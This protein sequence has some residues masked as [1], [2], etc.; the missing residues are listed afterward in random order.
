MLSLSIFEFGI[1]IDIQNFL[2][3]RLLKNVGIRMKQFVRHKGIKV[4]F[5]T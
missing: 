2:N 4:M 5:G 1:A 3:Y